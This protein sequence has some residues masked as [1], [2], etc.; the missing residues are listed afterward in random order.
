M[1]DSKLIMAP[2]NGNTHGTASIE[3]LSIPDA[4]TDDEW[5]PVLAASSDLWM[6]Y[7][8]VNGQAC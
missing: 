7:T 6:S 3:V 8:D 5:G 1:G 2:Q 4:V